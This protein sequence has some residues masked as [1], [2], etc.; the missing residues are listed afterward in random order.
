MDGLFSA[1]GGPGKGGLWAYTP[2]GP[3]DTAQDLNALF[4]KLTT[5]DG[6]MTYVFRDTAW[7]SILDGEWPTIKAAFE[8]WLA[9]E[10]FDEE[11][12]QKKRLSDIRASF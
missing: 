8:A 12:G 11:G 2:L 10:N 5:E 3:F 7:Y 9:P 4:T 6:W 1:L